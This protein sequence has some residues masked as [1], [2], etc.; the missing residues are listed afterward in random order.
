MKVQ[1]YCSVTLRYTLEPTDES[2]FP[3]P[4]GPFRMECLVGHGVLLP[5]LEE[6]IL[7]LEEGTSVEILLPPGAFGNDPSS[8]GLVPLPVQSIAEEGPHETGSIRHIMDDQRRLQ[9]FRIVKQD[10]GIV[11][12]D[13]SHPFAERSF[14]CR[15]CVEKLRWATLD[16]IKNAARHG[17]FH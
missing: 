11:W 4:T 12:A 9:P 2:P 16:E 7:G 17:A 3:F 8:K 13:F 10:E 1:P 15:V 5:S 6:A 14:L